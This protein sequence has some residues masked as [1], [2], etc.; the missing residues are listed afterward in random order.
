MGLPAHASPQSRGLKTPLTVYGA[1]RPVYVE[2]NYGPVC[3]FKRR[4][5]IDPYGYEH[6]R[7]V[8]VCDQAE[9]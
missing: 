7:R 4:G 3:H 2:D 6:V 5:Y 9:P 1:P 8:R